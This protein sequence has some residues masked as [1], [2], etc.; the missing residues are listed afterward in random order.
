MYVWRLARR[1]GCVLGAVHALGRQLGS[2]AG[3]E[4]LARAG[5]SSKGDRRIRTGVAAAA[6]AVVVM[7]VAV[8]VVPGLCVS[9]RTLVA[10]GKGP[11]MREEGEE[12]G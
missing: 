7:V 10:G 9:F 4:A 5:A 3:L 12:L 1:G 6:V 8:M 11:G 2:S